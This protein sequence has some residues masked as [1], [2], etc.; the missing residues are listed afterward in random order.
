MEGEVR[1][2]ADGAISFREVVE[3]RL[4][5][6]LNC[7]GLFFIL[8]TEGQWMARGGFGGQRFEESTKWHA[9]AVR[10]WTAVWLRMQ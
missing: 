7:G 1:S 3:C 5:A 10:R 4:C 9:K 6:G 8:R 2:V